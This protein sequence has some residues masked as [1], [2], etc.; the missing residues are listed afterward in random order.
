MF[1]IKT[2]NKIANEGLSLLDDKYQIVEEDQVDAII[3]RSFKMHDFE[4]PDSLESIARAGA[5]TNNVPVDKCSEKGIV[6][7]NTPGANAN[8]V[9]ELVIAGLLMSSR[10]IPGSLDFAKSL[11]DK[12]DEVPKLVESG[13]GAFVGP[14]IQGKT[15][16]VIGLG[17]IGV[18]VANAAENLG[19]TVLGFDPFISVD[20]AWGLSRKI[21]KAISVEEVYAKA[22][23]IT[24]HVPLMDAT[25]GMIGTDSLALMEDGV[26][27][28][29]F[30]RAELI[31]DDAIE[32]AIKSGKVSKYVTDF[33]NAKTIA[34][35]NVICIPH[36]GAST[37]ESEINCAI[38]AVE[39][40]KDYIENGN[41]K[42]SVNYPNCDMGI[43]QSSGRI[44]IN[45]K[46]IR[47][48]LGQISTVLAGKNFNIVDMINKSKGEVAY[49]LLDVEDEV[50]EEVVNAL[51][52][53]DG[54]V[55]V[56]VIK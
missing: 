33:P 39:Q 46:N 6:V 36:L 32:A 13:K 22:D 15:L 18:L 45:H 10:D 52:A 50:T 17:A 53:I 1:K 21:G 51:I 5:G 43:C 30:S 14:E 38:M 3:L 27:I 29:N 16:G 47:N 11:A 41:I 9:K 26:K 40:T 12:G 19:M 4:M 28:L 34:M 49:T 35:D 7:F 24:V 37:P 23:Y 48:M 56:R 42:N 20:A 8:G 31:D 54:I 44:A 2:L 55:K 25:K